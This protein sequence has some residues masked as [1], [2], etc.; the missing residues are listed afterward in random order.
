MVYFSNLKATMNKTE[1]RF[2]HYRW[3]TSHEMYYIEQRIIEKGLQTKNKSRNKNKSIN[4]IFLNFFISKLKF[5]G[6]LRI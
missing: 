1:I 3:Y 5:R 2:M 4:I 6:K